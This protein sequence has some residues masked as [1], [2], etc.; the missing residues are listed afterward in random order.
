MH[1]LKIILKTMMIYYNKI[2]IYNNIIKIKQK[3]IK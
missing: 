1:K 2:N 3:S